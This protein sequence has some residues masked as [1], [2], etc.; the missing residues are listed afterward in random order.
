MKLPLNRKSLTLLEL[1]VAVVL[2]SLVVIGFSSIDLFSNYHVLSSDKRA[3]LQNELYLVIEHMKKEMGKAVGNEVAFG[4]NSTVNLDNINGNQAIQV[5]LDGNGNGIRDTLIASPTENDDHWIAYV[6]TGST[7]AEAD[8][9][10]IWYYPLFID[11]N[12]AHEVIARHIYAITV[13]NGL[14]SNNNYLDI[15]LFTRWAPGVGYSTKN[16]QVNMQARINMHSVSTN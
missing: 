10:Q 16:P 4:A 11:S 2:F 7:G 13:T 12:S 1:L 8:R 9:Y 5:Y 14:S 3:R 6:F 15:E